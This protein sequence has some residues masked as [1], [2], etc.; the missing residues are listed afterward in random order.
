MSILHDGNTLGTPNM[1]Q[2]NKSKT[3]SW[4]HRA[5]S[6][7]ITELAN[8]T[9]HFTMKVDAK[10]LWP[11]YWQHL[12]AFETGYREEESRSRYK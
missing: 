7:R 3:E 6:S 5:S 8:E 9:F 4:G 12:L 2:A 11:R 10:E 1:T